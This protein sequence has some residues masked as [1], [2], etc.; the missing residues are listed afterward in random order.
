MAKWQIAMGICGTQV[1]HAKVTAKTKE[2]AVRKH[3]QSERENEY[4]EW[5]WLKSIDDM[6]REYSD[7]EYF[8]AMVPEEFSPKP[9]EYWEERY[10]DLLRKTSEYVPKKRVKKPAVE[11]D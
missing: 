10:E 9:E 8:E 2:E 1:M 3:I 7:P 4:A 11:A 5:E 6:H